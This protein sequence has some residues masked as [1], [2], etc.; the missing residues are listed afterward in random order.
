LIQ[1]EN[2]NGSSLKKN[3][4]SF[5]GTKKVIKDL[6]DKAKKNEIVHNLSES[7]IQDE[8]LELINALRLTSPNKFRMIND[9]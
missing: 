8:R 1:E 2:D 6:V 9:K 5:E 3:K 4:K 7:S